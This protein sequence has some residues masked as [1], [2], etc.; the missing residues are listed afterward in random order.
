MS[1]FLKWAAEMDRAASAFEAESDGGIECLAII[2]GN[3]AIA[4]VLRHGAS[5][6][7]KLAALVYASEPVADA[8][9]DMAGDAHSAYLDSYDAA[10][11]AAKVQP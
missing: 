5:I 11:A 4:D 2:D 1:Q 9:R 3:R 8:L 10:L 6:E 7:A